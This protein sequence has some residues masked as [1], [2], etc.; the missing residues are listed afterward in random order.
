MKL[1]GMFRIGFVAAIV[2][3][4]ILL[5]SCIALVGYDEASTSTIQPHHR[6]TLTVAEYMN[7]LDANDIAKLDGSS[8]LLDN[9]TYERIPFY[10][11]GAPEQLGTPLYFTN[12]PFKTVEQALR[13][14]RSVG[15]VDVSENDAK[16]IKLIKDPSGYRLEQNVFPNPLPP[17]GLLKLD[18]NLHRL[19]KLALFSPGIHS[20]EEHIEHMPYLNGKPILTQSSTDISHLIAATHTSPD[21]FYYVQEGMPPILV[22][23][24]KEDL[25]QVSGEQEVHSTLAE[26]QTVK[27]KYGQT[28]ATLVR[29][30][31]IIATADPRGQRKSGP[32]L[33][34]YARFDNQASRDEMVTELQLHGRF[35][36]YQQIDGRNYKYKVKVSNPGATEG[37]RLKVYVKPLSI[38]ERL[39]E[40]IMAGFLDFRFRG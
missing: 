6:S 2:T 18:P 28:I 26:Y 33:K 22:N 3:A 35:R 24:R 37:E 27:K 17:I 7:Q 1:S 36:V 34:N 9:P 4:L 8:L 25:Y 13:D 14:Y 38:R 19:Q 11:S 5:P 10:Y 15:M 23:P 30:K 40:K 29:G 12:T 39:Q 31:P 32:R 21:G 16:L 20:S